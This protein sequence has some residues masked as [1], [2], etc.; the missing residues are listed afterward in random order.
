MKLSV[1][2]RFLAMIMA[3]AVAVCLPVMAQTGAASPSGQSSTAT[4]Q[5][6][7]TQPGSHGH[8]GEMSEMHHGRQGGNMAAMSGQQFLQ[9]LA[10]ANQME[11]DMAQ[12]AEQKSSNQQVKDFARALQ[13]DHSK[14]QD[15]VQQMA[16]EENLSV[17]AP[18]ADQKSG[19]EA[20]MKQKMQS[21]SGAE[22]DKEFIR[23]QVMNHQREVAQLQRISQSGADPNSQ[24]LAQ[25]LLP[26]MQ[27]HLQTA[28]QLA[29]QLGVNTSSDQG[30]ASEK[31]H[32]HQ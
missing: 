13:Q 1:A 24:Q 12:L 26:D 16:Q 8:A 11:I 27:K 9:H 28:Q 19:K 14:A 21:L 6:T 3:V 32:P 18:G 23:H 22:F 25:Q 30:M 17:A 4:G 10:M 7:A 2:V 29:Q 15:A 31:H 20:M 5:S